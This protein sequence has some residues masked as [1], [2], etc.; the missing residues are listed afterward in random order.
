MFE[1]GRDAPADAD[2]DMAGWELGEP[3]RGFRKGNRRGSSRNGKRGF[4]PNGFSWDASQKKG[5]LVP[6]PAPPVV[7]QLSL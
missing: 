1:P 2:P 5:E 6:R 4:T 3:A 7:V